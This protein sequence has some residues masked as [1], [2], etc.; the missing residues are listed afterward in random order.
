MKSN[1]SVVFYN[2]SYSFA[3]QMFFNIPDYKHKRINKSSNLKDESNKTIIAI[4]KNK[5]WYFIFQP[6]FSKVN[7]KRTRYSTTTG[8][9]FGTN[10]F[11]MTQPM[12]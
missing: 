4:K 11:M 5:G 3:I 8:L 6:L 7:E 9:Y 12:R 10:A 1:K 2:Y